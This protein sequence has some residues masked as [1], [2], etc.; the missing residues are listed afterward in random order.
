MAS[1]TSIRLTPEM[2]RALSKLARQR[3]VPKSQL[4]REAIEQYLA[5]EPAGN[6]ALPMSVRERSAP[7]IGSIRLS[8]RDELDDVSARMRRQNWR[9]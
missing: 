7:Y 4:V 8:K 6:A 9:P 1:Q 3:G 2:L 5:T